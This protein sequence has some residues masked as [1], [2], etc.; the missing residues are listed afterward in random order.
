MIK[1]ERIQNDKKEALEILRECRDKGFCHTTYN[2]MQFFTA[3]DMS[4]KA[5]EHNPILCVNCKNFEKSDNYCKLLQINFMPDDFGCNK[6]SE[7]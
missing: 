1:K 2:A 3:R 5:L 6:G 4:I 7:D